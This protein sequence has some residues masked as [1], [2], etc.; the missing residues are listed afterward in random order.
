MAA[1]LSGH[2]LAHG[3]DGTVLLDPSADLPEWAAGVVTNPKAWVGGEAPSVEAPV[4]PEG[5]PSEDWKADELK[6]YAEAHDVD[7][8][9][10]KNKAEMVAALA[11][12]NG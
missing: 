4:F 5:D 1:R 11:A 7:L 12:A 3:P 2:V 6:A 8:A 9:G 10:A